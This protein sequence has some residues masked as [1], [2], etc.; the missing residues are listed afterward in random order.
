MNLININNQR[1]N[2]ERKV[3]KLNKSFSFLLTSRAGIRCWTERGR[4]MSNSTGVF[5]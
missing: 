5:Y 1:K 4:E 2:Q 3:D